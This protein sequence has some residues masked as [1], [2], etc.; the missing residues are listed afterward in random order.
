MIPLHASA[1][2]AQ[3]PLYSADYL[4]H[5]IAQLTLGRMAA[6]REVEELERVS[7]SESQQGLDATDKFAAYSDRED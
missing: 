4:I 1:Q 6:Q 3:Q 5:V 7:Q 2:D